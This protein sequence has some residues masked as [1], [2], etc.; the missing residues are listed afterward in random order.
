MP[1]RKKIYGASAVLSFMLM[2]HFLIDFLL[3]EKKRRT[4]PTKP[5]QVVIDNT[6]DVYRNINDEQ[7]SYQEMEA[8]AQALHHQLSQSEDEIKQLQQRLD[9]KRAFILDNWEGESP[10]E[11][12]STRLE[13]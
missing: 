4:L 9:A 13:P 10:I 5:P 11:V 8:I 12:G 1:V 7:F 3:E 6:A 2:C